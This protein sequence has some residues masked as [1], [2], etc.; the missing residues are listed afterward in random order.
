[1]P[2]KSEKQRKFLWANKPEVA[3][4]FE[5]KEKEMKKKKNCVK[6]LEDFEIDL[7]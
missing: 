1:M 4:E 2:F 5:E 7:F 6:S 3:K